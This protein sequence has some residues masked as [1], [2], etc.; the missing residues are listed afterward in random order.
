M[1][2]NGYTLKQTCGACP[3]QYDVFKGDEQVAYFRLRH[4][5]FSA[6]VP[7]HS[8]DEVYGSGSMIGDG[9]FDSDEREAFLTAAVNAV[10]EHLAKKEAA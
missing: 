4:G 2:I 6:R 9:C 1:E 7:N 10:D 5:Y 8:G 3:E